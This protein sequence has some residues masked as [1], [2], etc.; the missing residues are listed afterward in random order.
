MNMNVG[1]VNNGCGRFVIMYY[2][3]YCYGFIFFVVSMFVIV[4]FFGTLCALI[5]SVINFFCFV[6]FVLLNDIFIL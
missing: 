2:Y 4:K 6:F 5:A 3:V 1:I